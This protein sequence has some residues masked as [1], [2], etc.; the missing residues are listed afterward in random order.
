MSVYTKINRDEINIHLDKYSLGS[1]ISLTGISDGIENTNY[2]LKTD[3]NEYIFTIF[4][5]IDNT[6]ISNY[7]SFM[8]H[9]NEKG[10]LCPKV[11]K[12]NNDEL[13]IEIKSKPSAIIQKLPGKSVITANNSHCSQIGELL[14][15]F[16][17][18]GID[19]KVDLTNTRDNNWCHKS[20][21]KLSSVISVSQSNIIREAIKMQE[22]L[23]KEDLPKGTIHADLF[24]DNVLFNNGSISGMIDFY[25]SCKGYLIYDLAVVVNDWCSDGNGSIIFDKYEM[26]IKAYN[27]KR[28]ITN[29][30]NDLWK[31]SLISAALRF[32]LSRLLDLHFPKIGEMTHIKDPHIFENILLDRLKTDYETISDIN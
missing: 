3:R 29:K 1:V 20:F 27:K 4:E 31:H 9:L 11:M 15:N 28:V 18:Y 21:E 19:F 8:N 24:R 23:I 2:L 10:L 12:S 17:N 7:L 22:E 25:Y 5:N 14:A 30:E 6:N 16:H 13:F 26:L 32:Y